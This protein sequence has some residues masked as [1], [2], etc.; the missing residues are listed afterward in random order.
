MIQPLRT[1][2][3]RVSIAMATILP[4]VLILGLAA[5]HRLPQ[6]IGQSVPLPAS[7][8]FLKQSLSLWR[9]HSIRTSFYRNLNR[10]EELY[11]LLNST[12][13]PSEPDLLLY[14]S[15]TQ[16]VQ[17]A[18]PDGARLLGAAERDRALLLPSDLGNGGYLVIYSLAHQAV[19]DS[20]APGSTL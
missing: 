11:V 15:S 19:I 5:R 20:A 13:L 10:P 1:I 7:M 8:Q 3:R 16:P 17:N 6:T 2:H 14:W 4:A 9:K 18:L 12:D